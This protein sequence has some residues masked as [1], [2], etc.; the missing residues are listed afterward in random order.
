MLSER[1][2]IETRRECDASRRERGLAA[3]DTREPWETTKQLAARASV[4]PKAR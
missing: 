2:C 4:Y 3:I 1:D